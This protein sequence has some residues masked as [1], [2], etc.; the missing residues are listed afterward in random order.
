VR[1]QRPFSGARIEPTE[2]VIGVETVV[3]TIVAYDLRCDTCEF[4]RTVDGE[5]DA[6]ADAKDHESDNPDH[7]VLIYS[8][9]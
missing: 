7:F 8:V 4:D 6:Y 1:R 3:W 2:T 9:E 5:S